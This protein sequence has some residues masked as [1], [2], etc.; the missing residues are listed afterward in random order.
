MCVFSLRLPNIKIYIFH[1]VISSVFC[2]ILLYKHWNLIRLSNRISPVFSVIS[3]SLYNYLTLSNLIC[4]GDF[5]CANSLTL[6]LGGTHLYEP[7]V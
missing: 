7:Y 3:I 1:L 4:R 5:L 6:P 2:C